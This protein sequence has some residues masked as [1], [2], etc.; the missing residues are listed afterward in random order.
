MAVTGWY[1]VRFNS[2]GK[3]KTEIYRDGTKVSGF[4]HNDQETIRFSDPTSCT[5]MVIRPDAVYVVNKLVNVGGASWEKLP[6]VPT[7]Q[8]IQIEKEKL[9]TEQFKKRM[10]EAS[11]QLDR[12][13]REEVVKL[14]EGSNGDQDQAAGQHMSFLSGRRSGKSNVT[15]QI[16]NA[17][18]ASEERWEK[19]KPDMVRRLLRGWPNESNGE[20][21]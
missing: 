20:E 13:L 14:K 15:Q 9:K 12:V 16:L 21:A 4:F 18:T 1:F 8:Q 10:D 5:D 3:L 19:R 11:T 2:G 6:Q 7:D 17:F